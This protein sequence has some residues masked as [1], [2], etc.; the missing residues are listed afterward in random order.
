MESR[1]QLWWQKRLSYKTKSRRT[2]L[3]TT[4]YSINSVPQL[5]AKNAYR[6]Q[7]LQFLRHWAQSL[8]RYPAHSSFLHHHYLKACSF[9]FIGSFWCSRRAPLYFRASWRFQF[10]A[11]ISGSSQ[12]S[13]ST[14]EG[15]SAPCL[16]QTYQRSVAVVIHRRKSIFRLLEPACLSLVCSSKLRLSK[17]LLLRLG[18]SIPNRSQLAFNC[19]PDLIVC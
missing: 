9:A 13:W 10:R 12:D 1:R 11:A 15:Y 14:Q 8:S 7:T 16:Q 17:L 4:F 3:E 19:D 18:H 2:A 6:L 5:R